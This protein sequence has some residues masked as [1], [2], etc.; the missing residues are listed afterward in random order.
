[1]WYLSV[2]VPAS[3][4]GAA[5]AVARAVWPDDPE[6]QLSIPLVDGNGAAWVGGNAALSDGEIAALQALA[7]VPGVRFYRYAIEGD[8]A[9]GFA[10]PAGPR[11]G[12]TWGW[13]ESLAAAGLRA[14]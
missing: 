1:M 13:A 9:L 8:R 10:F 14:A 3:S 12:A 6:A 2:F 11:E 5:E 4:E 7:T